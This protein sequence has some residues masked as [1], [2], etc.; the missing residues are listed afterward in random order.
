M[1]RKLGWFVVLYLGGLV[2]ISIVAFAIRSMIM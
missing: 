2:T 1:R